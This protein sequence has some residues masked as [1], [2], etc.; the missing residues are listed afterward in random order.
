MKSIHCKVYWDIYD[1]WQEVLDQE[2]I[3]AEKYLEM[4]LEMIND[5]AEHEKACPECK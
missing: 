3:D 2:N 1:R 5:L 4:I